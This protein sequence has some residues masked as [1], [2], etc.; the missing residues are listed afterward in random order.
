MGNFASGKTAPENRLA[1]PIS[2]KNRFWVKVRQQKYLFLML[3][4]SAIL[5]IMFSYL[6]L[7]GWYMAFSNY[8]IGKPLF[9]GEFLGLEHFRSVFQDSSDLGYLVRNTLGMNLLSMFISPVVAITVALLLR[10]VRWKTGAKIVQ[11]ALFFPYFLSIVI[12]YAIVNSMFAVN[13]GVINQFLVRIGVLERGLNILG[14][15]KYAWGLM[16]GVG[17]WS[18]VGYSSVLYLAAMSGIPQEQYEAAELDGANRF[19]QAIHVT[20]PGIMPT[21]SVLFILSAGGILSSSLATYNMFCNGSNWPMMEVL[22]LYIYK[23]GLQL[24]NYSY[25]TAMGIITSIINFALVLFVNKLARKMGGNA[26]F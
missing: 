20:L 11:T 16:I 1:S 7:S 3:L 4:P 14:D 22:E 2:K 9:S 5:L 21:V 19:Q 23:Y 12:V 15:P 8:R 18:G 24:L 25:A 6:P 13:S 10:E 26:L 17:L